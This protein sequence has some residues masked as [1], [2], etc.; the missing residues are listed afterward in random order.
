MCV[1]S[2]ADSG[3][4]KSAL[5]G[6]RHPTALSCKGGDHR[7]PGNRGR[8]GAGRWAAS[9][10][11]SSQTLF[12]DTPVCSWQQ[13]QAGGLCSAGGLR[14]GVRGWAPSGAAP[15][16]QLFCFFCLQFHVRAHPART[17][18]GSAEHA[19]T[20]HHRS[21]LHLPVGD[22]GA[23]EASPCPVLGGLGAGTGPG[24]AAGLCAS[25]P[26]E[27][28]APKCAWLSRLSTQLAPGVLSWPGSSATSQGGCLGLLGA[29]WSCLGLPGAA[30][31]YLGLLGATWSF[32]GLPEQGL[33]LQP[34]SSAWVN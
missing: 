14:G 31:G 7:L 15:I 8:M 23:G 10:C 22:P 21:P 9:S 5:L 3:R 18:P 4:R 30:W 24:K 34:A 27:K 2:G 28:T 29:T 26:R 1:T 33:C 16:S 25:G 17:A 20:F 32:L 13:S 19:D 6:T 11:P 12:G